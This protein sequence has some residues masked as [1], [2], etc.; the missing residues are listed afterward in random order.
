MLVISGDPLSSVTG[1][2]IKGVFQG[3]INTGSNDFYYVDRK[4]Y[5]PSHP[6]T[7]HEKVHSVIYRRD[8]VDVEK[9]NE[10]VKVT[11]LWLL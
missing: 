6:R 8:D 4:E 7:K 1:S 9:F 3:M 11:Y 10:Y 2:I 5:H